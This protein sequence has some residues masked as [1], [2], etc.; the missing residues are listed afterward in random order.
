MVKID[1]TKVEERLNNAMQTMF[2]KKLMAGKATLSSRAVEFYRLDD[3]PRP[4]TEDTVIQGLEEL[5]EETREREEQARLEGLKALQQIPGQV[6][7]QQVYTEKAPKKETPQREDA[8][9]DDD[10]EKK[11]KPKIVAFAYEKITTTDLEERPPKPAFVLKKHIAWFKKK[12]IKDFYKILGTSEEET[13]ELCKKKTLTDL[14]EKR[15]DDI[16]RRAKPLKVALLKK[17]GVAEDEALIEKERKK[18]RTRRF[19]IR[20]SWL[21]LQ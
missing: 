11:L 15:V 19:N 10:E 5:E 20:D 17:L 12:K 3:G 9:D 8:S 2:V 7:A 4:K 21:P 18:H 14:E 6:G 13:K 16:L 1:F